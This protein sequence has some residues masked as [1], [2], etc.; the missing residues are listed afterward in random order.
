MNGKGEFISKP[1][2]NNSTA[3]IR[4]LLIADERRDGRIVYTLLMQMVQSVPF[5]ITTL[6]HIDGALSQLSEPYFDLVLLDLSLPDCDGIHTFNQIHTQAPKLPIII[7]SSFEDTAAAIEAV[8]QGAQDYLVKGQIDSRLLIRSIRYAIE[9][10]RWRLSSQT[11]HWQHQRERELSLLE[12]LTNYQATVVASKLYCNLPL[13]ETVSAEFQRLVEYYAQLLDLAMD[14]RQ[15]RVTHSI[16]EQM[17]GIA[18]QLGFLQASPRDVIALH[19]MA[20]KPRIAQMSS[21]KAE[22]YMEEARI[23][24]LQLMGYL[25]SYYR[26]FHLVAG[27][28]PDPTSVE[29]HHELS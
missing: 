1:Q 19:T 11:E 14:Q 16:G 29:I 3:P 28:R 5:V 18:Q 24:V 2:G 6:Q 22:A 26:K 9:R 15:F 23:M 12:Q 8:R 27:P 20:I 21:V 13:E 10:Q 4:I 17:R 7:L 25:A